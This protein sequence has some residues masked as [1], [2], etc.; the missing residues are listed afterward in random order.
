MLYSNW[1]KIYSWQNCAKS[2]FHFQSKRVC[3]SNPPNPSDFKR[4]K[5]TWGLRVCLFLLCYV[6]YFTEFE[7]FLWV[8]LIIHLIGALD[9]CIVEND[10]VFAASMPENTLDICLGTFQSPVSIC[11]VRECVTQ[12]LQ[13]LQTSRDPKTRVV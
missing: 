3:Y 11:K 12:T 13:I 1:L 4:P 9:P 7:V 6:R 2:S 8:W 5:N 10:T